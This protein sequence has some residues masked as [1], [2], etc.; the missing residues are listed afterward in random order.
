MLE[1]YHDEILSCTGCGFCKKPYN[2]LEFSQLES[3][4]PKGKLMIAYGILTGELEEDI[5]VVRTLQKCTLCKRCEKDCPSLI[6][7]EEIIQAA[8]NDLKILLPSHKEL[9]ANV[10]KYN[11]IFGE[12]NFE[13]KGGEVGFFMGCSTTKSMKN[14]VVSIFEKLGIDITFIS[15]C[16][17]HPLKKIGKPLNSNIKENI[18]KK[19]V[20]TLIFSCP[21]GMMQTKDLNPM[22]ISQYILSKK[23]SFKRTDENYIYHDPSY[24]GRFLGIY[25][26]PR[27]IIKSIGNLIEFNENKDLSQWCGGE[28]EFRAE[29]THEAE[30]LALRL[31]KEAKNKD[32]T[33]IT[34]SPHCYQHLDNY[35]NVKD[36]IHLIEENIV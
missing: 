8:R 7:I 5:D 1:K 10:E 4:Y 21:N 29:F 18:L 14:S 27:T 16:C 20:K 24:L 6:K 15:G 36:I 32:A 13:R 28:I 25:N 22:H 17:G 31:I 26:E 3:D 34:A 19:E 23:V 11:N 33:I 9:L 2:K 12:E 35:G 30:E